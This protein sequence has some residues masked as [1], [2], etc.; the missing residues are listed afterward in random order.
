VP[1]AAMTTFLSNTMT[2]GPR[3][4]RDH[5]PTCRNQHRGADRTMTP[6]GVYR[7]CR[8]PPRRPPAPA[9]RDDH[10]LQSIGRKTHSDGR[11]QLQ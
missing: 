5:H 10:T 6:G 1:S 7:A 9:T 11:P 2:I 8:R 3:Q 4:H